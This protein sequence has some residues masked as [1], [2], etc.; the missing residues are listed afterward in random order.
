V[1]YELVRQAGGIEK[2]EIQDHYAQVAEEIY[3]GGP[4][5]PICDRERR[6]KLSKL[7][8]YGLIEETG[9]TATGATCPST[10]ASLRR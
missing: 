8:D 2:D 7:E 9:R 1:L 3:E 4:V 5:E 10:S 6:R